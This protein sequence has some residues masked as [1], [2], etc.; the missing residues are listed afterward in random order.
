M[1]LSWEDMEQIRGRRDWRIPIPPTCPS[2]HYNLTGLS[3]N[4][5]PEC[6][7]IFNWRSVR[8]RA[9]RIWSTVNTVRH[10]GRDAKTA[11]PSSSRSCC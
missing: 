3:S 10:A 2:C 9:G 6:G 7:Q 1:T 8:R 11:G 4:R 5:C